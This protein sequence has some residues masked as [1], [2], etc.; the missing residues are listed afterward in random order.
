MAQNIHGDF[1]WYELMTPDAAAAQ[2]FYGPVIG[3]TVSEMGPDYQL[4]NIEGV[5][6]AG[7]M[8]SPD[9]APGGSM[10]PAWVGYVGVTDVDA[11]AAAL[12]ADGG[13]VW[14]EPWDIPG[15]GR[16]AVVADAQGVAFCIMRGASEDPSTSF[17]QS[18][19]GHCNWNEMA[20]PD[21]EA[22]L[23]FWN[24]HFGW[25]GGEVMPM[26]DMGDYTFIDHGG[27]TIGAVMRNMGGRPPS[28]LY[29]FGVIDID[30]AAQ[31]ITPGGGTIHYGPSEIPGGSF[32]IVATDPQGAWFGLVGPRTA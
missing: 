12:K 2:A 21:P 31:A 11:T 26:G 14:K 4:W 13:Q 20:T 25:T 27:R 8:E 15:V 9:C 29:Y 17:D 18:A 24:R 7:L 16:M 10:P 5:P 1:I 22:A 3:W 30:A 32:I 19:V 23:A 6:V 28:L